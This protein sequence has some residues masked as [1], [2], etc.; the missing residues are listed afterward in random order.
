MTPRKSENIVR[1]YQKDKEIESPRKNELKENDGI[2]DKIKRKTTIFTIFSQREKNMKESHNLS[3]LDYSVL[4][5]KNFHKRKKNELLENLDNS[6]R[7]QKKIF[8]EFTFYKLYFEM[9]K[10]KMI[11]FDETQLRAFNL[12]KINSNYLFCEN[13]ENYSSCKEMFNQINEKNDE[14][15]KKMAIFLRKNL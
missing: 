11:L 4:W 7:M 12:I 3:F 8:N 10:L 15:S 5:I 13:K 1:S 2:E 6:Q 9:E 14:L